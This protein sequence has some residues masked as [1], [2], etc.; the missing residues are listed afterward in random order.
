MLH[1][2]EEGPEVQVHDTRLVPG[3]GRGDPVDAA[4]ALRFGRYPYDP[5]WKSASK[6]GSRMSFTAPWT[7]RSQIVGIDSRR[8]WP[9]PFGIATCRTGCGR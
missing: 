1:R 8:V 6:I 7:T 2:I 3:N 4:W 9:P 5:G